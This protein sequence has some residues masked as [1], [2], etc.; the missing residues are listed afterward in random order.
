MTYY[1]N[2]NNMF[3]IK[4]YDISDST[5]LITVNNEIFDCSFC[6]KCGNYLYR[7]TNQDVIKIQCL[8]NINNKIFNNYRNFIVEIPDDYSGDE[9]DDYIENPK[10]VNKELMYY[11]YEMILFGLIHKKNY[12]YKINF[13]TKKKI[14]GYL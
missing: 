6:Y 4:R 14:I 10:G 1:R 8:C 12:M 7:K 13:E 3:E 2:T 9:L 11:I 5:M